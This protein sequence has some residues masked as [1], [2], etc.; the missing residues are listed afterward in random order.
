MHV[1]WSTTAR[2]VGSLA[3]GSGSTVPLTHSR[4]MP[5]WPKIPQSTSDPPGSPLFPRSS[6]PAIHSPVFSNDP[7]GLI[8]NSVLPAVPSHAIRVLLP[9]GSTSGPRWKG[10]LNVR[11]CLRFP[12]LLPPTV[13]V[14]GQ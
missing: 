2:K 14:D 3:S 4:V 12:A 11:A 8:G 7:F 1:R 6:L 13:S 9:S 10:F 5:D